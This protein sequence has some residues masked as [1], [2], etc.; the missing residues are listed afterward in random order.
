MTDLRLAIPAAAVWLGAGLL[1]GATGA[2]GGVA[3]TAGVAAGILILLRRWHIVALSLVFVALIAVVVL[4]HA[5]QRSSPVLDEAAASS[6]HVT[7]TAQFSRADGHATLIEANGLALSVPV[8]IRGDLDKPRIGSIAEISGTVRASDPGDSTAYLFFATSVA[9]VADPPWYLSWADGLRTG[10]AD[11]AAGFGGNGAALLPGLAIGDVSAVSAELNAAM[12]ASSLTHLTAVSGSNCAVVVGLIVALGRALGLSRTTRLAAAGLALVGFVVLVTPQA[13]VLRAAAMALIVLLALGSGRPVSGLP[14]LSFAVISLVVVD[15]WLA[16]DYGFALSVL[17]TGGLLLLARPLA[18]WLTRWLPLPLATVV[19]VPL[20]AQVCCQPV[21]ILLQPSLPTYGVIANV[22]AE[23]AAPVATVLGLLACLTLPFIPWLGVALAWVAWIPSSWIAA[24]AT[25]FAGLPFAAVPWPSGAVGFALIAV[26][27]A[28]AIATL[29]LSGRRRAVSALAASLLV[30]ALVGNVVGGRVGELID[31]PHDWQIAMCDV[32]QGD[33]AV[34]RSGKSIAVI[35]TGPAPD[36]MRACLTDLGI[37][38]IDLLVLSHYDLDHVGGT[39][40]VVGMVD[41]VL[42]GPSSGAD[43]D[44]L[45]QSLAAGGARVTSASRGL[46]G[47]LG[48]L[49]WTILWPRARLTGIEPGN[50]ASVT[51]AFAGQP[52]CSCLSSV[53]LGDLGE[54]AQSLVLAAGPIARVDVVKVAH[55]GSADQN[56]RT[57]EALSAAIGLIGVGAGNTYGHPTQLLLDMLDANGTVPFR[58]DRDG[59]VLVRA[60]G[61]VWTQREASVRDSAPG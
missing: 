46:T 58:T 56:P 8:Y 41:D 55:H 3:V 34:V 16:R 1:I 37:D 39:A 51:I 20:A 33:A 57:Y 38:H 5:S 7:A 30:L 19:A 48:D 60:D 43:D 45:V 32:G 44:A 47:T 52:D 2:A 6:R 22:L 24:V 54:Q 15:P 23:P 50:P 28:L 4:V 35:D 36:R 21:L 14:V 9:Y 29:F 26:I 13:S 61:T 12:K 59:L 10:F 42:I 18:S 40:A 11:A 17:A 27:T 31:R 49:G 25:F 53:F